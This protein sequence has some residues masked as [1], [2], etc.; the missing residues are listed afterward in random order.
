MEPITQQA[1]NKKIISIC[2]ELTKTLQANSK[3][4]NSLVILK[5]TKAILLTYKLPITY[6][7]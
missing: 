5:Q 6:A 7:R 2:Q 1:M 3:T 4:D